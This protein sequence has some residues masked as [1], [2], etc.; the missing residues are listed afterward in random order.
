MHLSCSFFLFHTHFFVQ[1]FTLTNDEISEHLSYF[2]HS[3]FRI[4]VKIVQ[5]VEIFGMVMKQQVNETSVFLHEVLLVVKKHLI[6][7]FLQNRGFKFWQQIIFTPLLFSIFILNSDLQI[8]RQR[9]SFKQFIAHLVIKLLR[10]F[11]QLLLE[12][13][14]TLNFIRFQCSLLLGKLVKDTNSALY[15]HRINHVI[16]SFQVYLVNDC[17]YYHL[18]HW[19]EGYLIKS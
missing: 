11:L 18:D 7:K 16:I 1:F 15:H 8:L 3:L 4:F 5:H 14:L 10:T 13:H 19:L 12:C 9:A 17:L 6:S 2:C